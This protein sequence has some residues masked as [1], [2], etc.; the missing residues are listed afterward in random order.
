MT[1]PSWRERELS[2]EASD[3]Y[4]INVQMQHIWK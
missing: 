2:G 4:V 1:Q 3:A